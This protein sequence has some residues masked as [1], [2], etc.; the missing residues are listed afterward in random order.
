MIRRLAWVLLPAAFLLPGVGLADKA[1]DAPSDPAFEIVARLNSGPGNI[2]ITPDGRIIISQHQFYEPDLAVVEIL[3]DGSTQAF[4]TEAWSRPPGPDGIGMTSVLGLRSDAAGIVWMLDN[5]SMPAKLVAWDT[6]AESLHRVI[7]I[8]RPAA[9]EGSFLNDLAVDPKH[10]AIYIADIGPGPDQAALVVVELA[11][12]TAR[13]VLEGDRSTRAEDVSMVIDGTP[14][15]MK[16][17][18][19]SVI[20]P[21]IGVNPITIDAAYDWVYFGAMHGTTLYRV[22]T[23]DLLDEGLSAS[24]LSERVERAGEK[25]VSDGITIDAANNV[26]VSSVTEN[27]IGVVR[28]DGSYELLFSDPDWLSWPD[29]MSCGPDGLVYATVNRLHLSARLNAGVAESKPPYYVVRFKPLAPCPV[30]R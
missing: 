14:V 15:K 24:E 13:R 4:P 11:T 9:I 12:G 17:A 3:T 2:A 22:R 5:A 21:R 27:G 25:P 6:R 8:P 10:Q 28:P 16:K 19:G 18:D 1:T 20:E 29:G 30:G 23:T 26:Y 7:D